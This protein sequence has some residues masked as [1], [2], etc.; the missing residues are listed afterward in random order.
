MIN[1]QGTFHRNGVVR[2]LAVFLGI[3]LLANL[4]ACSTTR[5][6]RGV[7]ESGFLQDYSMLKPGGSDRAKL[8]Y[9]ADGVNWR[10]FT[11]VYIVPIQLWRGDETNSPLGELSRDNQQM[12]VNFF[13]TSLNNALQKSFAMV[14]QPGVDTLVIKAAITEARKSRPVSNLIST[15]V[16]VGLAVSILKTVA[17]GKGLSVGDAQVEA[18][19]L[20]GETNQKL[21][22]VVDRRVGTKALRTKFDGTF[23]DVK[24]A[25]DYWSNQLATRLA[26][27][28][29]GRVK[30][31]D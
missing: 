20:D 29:V 8:L 22:A 15:V 27:N 25:M 28:R 16:P 4:V 10:K 9:V 1:R 2:A 3:A 19:L 12:L 6:A 11:K 24:E 31:T 21:A 23:G 18:E 7:T 17:F 30:A 14:D 26:E 5:Q 13:H